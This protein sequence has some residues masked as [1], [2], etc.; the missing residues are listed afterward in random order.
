MP[1]R[2]SSKALQLSWDLAEHLQIHIY[3]IR[4]YIYMCIYMYVYMYIYMCV[5]AYRYIYV[6]ICAYNIL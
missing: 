2:S 5:C 4:T 1:T 6:E 3:N